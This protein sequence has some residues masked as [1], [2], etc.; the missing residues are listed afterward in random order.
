MKTP[1]RGLRALQ[2]SSMKI[3]CLSCWSSVIPAVAF[4][5]CVSCK[6]TTSV[7]VSAKWVKLFFRLLRCPRPLQLRVAILIAAMSGGG[8]GVLLLLLSQPI[9]FLTELPELAEVQSHT[10]QGQGGGRQA[11]RDVAVARCAS[12]PHRCLIGASCTARIFP[13]RL[14][15]CFF[16]QW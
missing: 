1:S 8:R 10:C 9:I 7:L 6:S 4:V 2:V 14:S 11:V 16:S 13:A 15:G 12:P 5:V 3:S